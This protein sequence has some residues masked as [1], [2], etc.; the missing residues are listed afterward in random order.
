MV[1]A[2]VG[3]DEDQGGEG[4]EGEEQPEE[5]KLYRGEKPGG[6]EAVDWGELRGIGGRGSG[7]AEKR[8][9]R[10]HGQREDEERDEELVKMLGRDKALLKRRP[11]KL[12]RA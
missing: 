2:I 8:I 5:G 7:N 12:M 10:L 11:W 4:V 3:E 6:G 9:E 1:G